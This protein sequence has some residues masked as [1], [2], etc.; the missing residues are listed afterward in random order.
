MYVII[1]TTPDCT[2][3]KVWGPFPNQK[4]ALKYSESFKDLEHMTIKIVPLR[5][6]SRCRLS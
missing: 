4:R 1:T 3:E 2:E 5:S 6:T